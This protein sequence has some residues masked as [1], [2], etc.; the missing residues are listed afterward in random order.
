MIWNSSKNLRNLIQI[1]H[2]RFDL[3]QKC[4]IQMVKNFHVLSLDEK[5]S[6]SSLCG[7]WN[8]SW[9]SSKSLVT[10][11]WCLSDTHF[12]SS[13]THPF[14]MKSF[15]NCFQS[16]LDEPNVSSPANSEAANLYQSNRRE[17]EKRV[18]MTVEQSWVAEPT[19]ASK[20]QAPWSMIDIG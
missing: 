18:K 2:H 17:Y 11:I 3:H 9:Y 7:W 12:H 19:L 8:L 20:L 15:M 1:S 6:A 13:R 5:Q 10:D 16:L 14:S 4:F